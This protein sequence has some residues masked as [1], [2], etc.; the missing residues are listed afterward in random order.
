MKTE[1][2]KIIIPERSSEELAVEASTDREMEIRMKPFSNLRLAYF[3]NSHDANEIE[4]TIRIFLE[5]G[6]QLDWFSGIFSGIA[7]KLI[8]ETNL[9]GR[10]SA[11]RQQTIYFGSESESFHMTSNTILHAPETKAIVESKGILAGSA[12]ARFDG[13]IRITEQAKGGEGRLFEHTLLLS[14]FAKMNAIPGLKIE[15]DDVAASHS[16]GVTRVDDDQMFY[17]QA[18]GIGEQEATRMIAK[19]FLEAIY[20]GTKWAERMDSI[21]EEKLCRV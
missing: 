18:R 20:G 10:G 8:F 2:K 1:T 6:A 19:G 5:E 15:T 9:C 3:Q 4:F 17:A 16:A 11:V 7:G 12:Q 14:P 13:N 21:I